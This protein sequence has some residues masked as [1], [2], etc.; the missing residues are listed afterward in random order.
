M[1][2][3]TPVKSKALTR[4]RSFFPPIV[5][6]VGKQSD[7]N[8]V[9]RNVSEEMNLLSTIQ[10]ALGSLSFFVLNIDGMT[11]QRRE[12]ICWKSSAFDQLSTEK[13]SLFFR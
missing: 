11:K 12:V 1:P 9:F 13:I 4:A 8:F 10:T 6:T 2:Y 5:V 7:C 3:P